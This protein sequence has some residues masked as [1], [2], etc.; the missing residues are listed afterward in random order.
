[1]RRRLLDCTFL[2]TAADATLL[3]TLALPWPL[4]PLLAPVA[5]AATPWPTD[6]GRPCGNS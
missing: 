3:L 4:L 5:M 6:G 2:L 1:M